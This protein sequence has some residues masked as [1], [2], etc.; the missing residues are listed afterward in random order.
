MQK[1]QRILLILT[2]GLL[3]SLAALFAVNQFIRPV[4]V[5]K[6]SYTTIGL[7][8]ALFLALLATGSKNRLSYSIPSKYDQKV[9]ISIACYSIFLLIIFNSMTVVIGLLIPLGYAILL[10][11]YI[12][13]KEISASLISQLALMFVVSASAKLTVTYFYIGNM[14]LIK[15]TKF[16]RQLLQENS[17]SAITSNYEGF[18]ALHAN[19]GI[20][21]ETTG[22]TPHNSI[23]ILGIASFTALIGILFSFYRRYT[24]SKHLAFLSVFLL[25]A[26]SG[27]LFFS[28]YFY[29]QS[30]GLTFF[31]IL[32]YIAIA[33]RSSLIYTQMVVV[34]FIIASALVITHHFS[35]VLMLPII[36]WLLATGRLGS[37]HTAR[38]IDPL[39]SVLLIPYL[40]ALYYWGDFGRTFFKA[41]FGISTSVIETFGSAGISSGGQQSIILLGTNPISNSISTAVA[42]LITPNGLYQITLV[43]L[44][45]LG[46][47][48][49]LVNFD[50]TWE[51]GPLFLLGF[52]G[53]GLL[54][55]TPLTLKSLFRLSFPFSIFVFVVCGLGMK[56]LID[57]AGSSEI[58]IATL[59]VIVLVTL[60]VSSGFLMGATDI[61]H[62]QR[63][64]D[65]RQ[66]SIS[67]SEYVQFQSVANFINTHKSTPV[68]SFVVSDQMLDLF[69]ASSSSTLTVNKSIKSR[70]L[71]V[72]NENWPK[73]RLRYTK[74][75]TPYLR[76]VRMSEPWLQNYTT[77]TNIV[78]DAGLI[79]IAENNRSVK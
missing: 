38:Q 4:L 29:P 63:G 22:F 64:T 67:E 1:P 52:A 46:V 23:I 48:C 69:G 19:A 33:S 58:S 21:S 71:L 77:T 10:L 6:A 36:A 30:L 9:L 35:F 8:T 57:S 75:G 79:G 62:Y 74:D 3:G 68:S 65:P 44:L 7:V 17:P 53:A 5:I 24:G 27:Y 15:H 28:N 55:D 31:F 41:L 50:Q 11:Q 14:D 60:F 43:A 73:Y 37:R 12:R 34:G 70:H 16:T 39:S 42:W 49:F 61:G 25:S 26:S 56:Y 76:Y 13:V 47:A 40:I 45:S 20:I 54:L 2:F 18:F 72:Y 78:Y 59:S 51:I 66:A 32:L